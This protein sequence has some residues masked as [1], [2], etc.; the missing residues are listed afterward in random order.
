MYTH[1]HRHHQSECAEE[2][3]QRC[4]DE[5]ADGAGAEAGGQA[6]CRIGCGSRLP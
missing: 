6:S 3:Q 5:L 4:Q 1:G 2:N